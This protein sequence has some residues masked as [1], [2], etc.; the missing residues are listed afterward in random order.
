MTI[1]RASDIDFAK[2][3]SLSTT[4]R[5]AGA[6]VK[7]GRSAGASFALNSLSKCASARCAASAPWN[8]V[9]MSRA[10]RRLASY[11]FFRHLSSAAGRSDAP[12]DETRVVHS[13]SRVSGMDIVF[14]YWSSGVSVMPMKLS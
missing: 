11:G 13:A 1:R 8:C 10:S 7:R 5:L 12:S 14:P 9:T 3:M 2:P 6:C 4:A